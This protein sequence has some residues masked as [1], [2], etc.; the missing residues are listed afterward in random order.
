M[1]LRRCPHGRFRHVDSEKPI[2]LTVPADTRPAGSRWCVFYGCR[3][4]AALVA[5][6]VSGDGDSMSVSEDPL[7]AR[8]AERVIGF[9][10]HELLAGG[11][12]R[13]L[14]ISPDIWYFRGG[15]RAA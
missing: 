8:H 10:V 9:W 14:S 3:Q 4:D 12:V 7:C 1:T 11:P 13:H 5:V 15:E 2:A 6:V